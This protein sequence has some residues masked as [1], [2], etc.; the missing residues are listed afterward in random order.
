MLTKVLRGIVD[1]DSDLIRDFVALKEKIA[2]FE[3]A[4][5]GAAMLGP[6]KPW[7]AWRPCLRQY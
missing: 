7:T 5:A 2:K 3:N 1:G 6:E 4:M